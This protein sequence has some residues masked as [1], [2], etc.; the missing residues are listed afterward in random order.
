MVKIIRNENNI[1]AKKSGIIESLN[2][3]GHKEDS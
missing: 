1:I 3:L 2:A